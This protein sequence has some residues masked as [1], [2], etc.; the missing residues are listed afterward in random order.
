[1]AGPSNFKFKPGRTK[2]KTSHKKRGEAELV[3]SETAVATTYDTSE[4]GRRVI[5]QDNVIV[6][7]PPVPEF[8][9][10]DLETAHALE[11]ADFSYL[12]GSGDWD[13]WELGV[14]PGPDDVNA[15]D[16]DADGEN[17]GIDFRLG[18][19]G[20]DG[21]PIQLERWDDAVGFNIKSTEDGPLTHFQDNPFRVFATRF[22]EERL[23]EMLRGEGRGSREFYETCGTCHKP[24]PL[25][26]C[27]RQT[28]IGPSMYCEPCIADLHRQLP[29]HTIEKWDGGFF[30]P[31]SLNDL[32]VEARIQLGHA[33]GTFCPRERMAHKDFVIIDVLG[34]RVVKLSFCGCDSRLENRQQL[35]RACLWPAT[36]LNP[37]TCATFNAI[38]L[39]EVQ[40]CLGKISAYDFVRSLELL[41]NN[42]GLERS[43]KNT[44]KPKPP[45][46]RRRAFRSIVRQYRMMEMLKRRGRGHADSGISGTKQGELGLRCRACPQPGWN[47]PEG[48]DRIN[49]DEMDEDQRYKYF[50]ELAEDANFKLIN[51]Q[52]STEEKDPIVDDGLGYFGNRVEYMQ[53]IRNNVD[54]EEIGSC[55]GFQAM[56]LA[57]VK[58]VKGLRV[59]GVG[60][61]TCAR[62]NMWLP[63]GIGD[64]Q[65]G[66]RQCNM[67]FIFFS[68]VLGMVMTFLVLSY[69]VA[70]QFSKHIW[71]RMEKLPE[72]YHLKLDRA[73]V[74]WMVPNFHLPAHKKGCHSPFS[75]HWL[76]GA[77]CTHGETVEQN[78]EFLNGIAGSTKL[79]GLGARHTALERLFGFHNWRRLLMQRMAD[80][81]K[82]GRKQ[83]ASFD[84]FTEGLT[85]MGN[86]DV[87]VWRASVDKW[88]KERHVEGDKASPYEYEEE[89]ACA[90]GTTLKDIRLVLAKEEYAS[91]GDGT[92]VERG[93]TPS[94]FI[95]MGMD[96]ENLAVA[97]KAAGPTP[98][99][100]QQLDFLKRRT[101]LRVRLGAFRKVQG[102]FMP[103]ARRYLTVTQRAVWDADD[104][105]PEATRLF[106]PSDL[107]SDERRRK[108]CARGLDGVEARLRK[109]EASEALA[110][111]RRALRTRT[112]TNR[113]K[114]R[115]W[116]GQRALTRGQGILRQVNIRIHSAKLRYRYARQALLKLKGHG[117]WEKDFRILTDEDVRALSDRQLREEEQAQDDFLGLLA[118][119]ADPEK[120][121]EVLR[122]EG[123]R[124]LSWIWYTTASCGTGDAKLHEALRVEWCKAY[125]RC[126]RLHEELVKVEEEMRRTIHFGETEHELWLRRA[127]ARTVMLGTSEAVTPEVLE[128]SRAYALE[129][130]RRERTTCDRL[131]EEWRPIR[132]RGAAYLRGEEIYGL[133]EVVIEVD[134][135]QL[136]WSEARMY[137]EE[138]NENDLYSG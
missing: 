48:W 21:K 114:I 100:S 64:L 80:A 46:D 42:D 20:E 55:S 36:C 50:T 129:Q 1:M 30:E 103:K 75:F 44:G 17:D 34:I 3:S 12:V 99:T 88:E 84:A 76:W 138:E 18:A 54:E 16:G 41:S 71:T 7:A 38:R 25:F 67:D 133:P 132:A 110:Q 59:T 2:L 120:R 69:D 68:A 31:L 11:G 104:Q 6:T 27:A 135:D 79:M 13:D 108:A 117:D 115:N 121:G 70:C 91:T 65:M 47:L 93:D 52:V 14:L 43:F 74:R 124:V 96:I 97:I 113:F 127:E 28:C 118:V 66:E 63:N 125:S 56:F 130:V 102:T 81:I 23:D 101:A 86:V 105:H 53:H 32:D 72:K 77:G 116:S 29:T 37:Q 22:R 83:R 94:T 60:G 35:M 137:Q 78:W 8:H 90:E 136:R 126:N 82:E 85:E 95:S 45:P 49:W 58:R 5:T 15:V 131:M 123:H 109:A 111:L 26:R 51:R 62:H 134:E 61:V 9:A 106:M 87:A 122:G 24:G 57:N 10:E 19:L 112:M 73:N 39:F 98:S 119:Q 40:N 4:D 107:A 33:P 128:G 92:E 89:G